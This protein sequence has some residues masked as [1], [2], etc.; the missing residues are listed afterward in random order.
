MGDSGSLM[1]GYVVGVLLVSLGHTVEGV[2]I[3][4]L[5][6]V[7]ALPLLD[8]LLVMARRV[9]YGHSPFIPDRTHLHHRLLDLGLPHPAV[10]G[11]IYCLMFTFGALAIVLSASPEWIIFGTL[12]GVGSLVF[13]IVSYLQH[14]GWRY[15]TNGRKRKQS[16]KQWKSFRHMEQALRLTAKPLG[17]L[18]VAALLFP[19]IFGSLSSFSSHNVLMLFL[20]S[21]L[22]ATFS[23]RTSVSNKGILHGTMYL[24]IFALQV[25]YEISASRV[26]SWLA[27]YT[28]LAAG[29]VL[30]W[31]LLKLFFSTHN[32][33]VFA[34]GFELLMI[35]VSW[36][37]PFV[38]LGKLNLSDELV[39]AIQHACLSSIPYMLAMKI[40]IRNFG[41]HNRWVAAPLVFGL[42]IVGIRAM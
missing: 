34:S 37:I 26:P 17:I 40:N 25:I 15:N 22:M 19:A 32:E 10:V 38:V 20:I 13:M 41:G 3:V 42:V 4:S 12:C 2:P 35:F 6:T 39:R 29:I 27:S 18:I 21:L 9:R 14:I 23:W 36:F 8:T 33:I 11:L 5:A 16:I 7:V 31:V 28:F 30:L 24:A 1:A